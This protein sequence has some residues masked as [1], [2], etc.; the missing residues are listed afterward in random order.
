MKLKFAIALFSIVIL[1]PGFSED[2][3]DL[4]A[5]EWGTFTQVVGSDGITIPW[6]TPRLT[7]SGELPEFVKPVFRMGMSKT[8]RPWVVRMETP[9]IYFYAERP[10]QDLRVEVDES[11]FPSTEV[12]PASSTPLFS[13]FPQAV[14]DQQAQQTENVEPKVRQ[15]DLNLLPP[16]D[17][18]GGLLPEIGPRGGH[19]A[20]AREV[21]EAWWVVNRSQQSDQADEVEKFIFYRGVGNHGMPP[22]IHRVKSDS[23]VFHATAQ[24]QFVIEN[25]DGVFSWTSFRPTG[26]QEGDSLSIHP[27]P[28]KSEQASSDAEALSDALVD[29]LAASGLAVP[30]AKAMVATWSNSWLE[31]SGLR[32]LEILPRSWIDESLPLR[33]TPQPAETERVFVGRWELFRPELEEE[34]LTLL[35][36]S[37]SLE[38]G[39]DR[40]N[41][42]DLGRFGTALFDRVAEIRAFRFRNQW[43]HEIA[44]MSSAKP[45][46]TVTQ[47]N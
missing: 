16:S 23:L 30:E 6:W 24:L 43:R 40:A 11:S 7:E 15:W 2:R 29:E 21:P 33:I 41:S 14:W 12:Y 45:E 9:V 17:P 10:I 46:Q 42:L 5:H 1:Q 47:S 3:K 28:S 39:L 32:V 26:E 4:V 25:I 31:E 27:L 18:I 19:Y 22:R 36:E 35:E 20:H 37:P 44:R 34:L 8:I 38:E 13:F